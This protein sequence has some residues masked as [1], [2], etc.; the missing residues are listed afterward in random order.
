MRRKISLKPHC[1]FQ[2]VSMSGKEVPLQKAMVDFS[3]R[4]FETTDG[5]CLQHSLNIAA[6]EVA[7]HPVF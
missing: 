6:D 1:W 2:D 7:V 3:H 4:N 5:Y